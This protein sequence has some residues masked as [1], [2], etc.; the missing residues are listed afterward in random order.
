MTMRRFGS[1]ESFI[2]KV[3]P[4]GPLYRVEKSKTVERRDFRAIAGSI[5]WKSTPTTPRRAGQGGHFCSCRQPSR[6]G[7]HGFELPFGQAL[8]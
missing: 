1:V 6:G 3:G 7:R 2:S 5:Q 8:A 4:F